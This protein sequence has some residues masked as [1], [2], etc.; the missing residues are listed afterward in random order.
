[1]ANKHM[2]RYSMSL[3]IR[4]MQIETIMRKKNI[5]RYHFISTRVAMGRKPG[6]IQY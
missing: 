4:E 2:K 3:A 6:N 1:M 5:M